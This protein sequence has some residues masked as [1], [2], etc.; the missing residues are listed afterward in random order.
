MRLQAQGLGDP[1]GLCD[2]R[3][4][5][6][7]GPVGGGAALTVGQGRWDGAGG[8][9]SPNSGGAGAGIGKQLREAGAPWRQREAKDSLGA[10]IPQTSSGPAP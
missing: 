6:A 10:C 1:I 5:I 4:D 9:P 2:V 8:T 7:S 3:R